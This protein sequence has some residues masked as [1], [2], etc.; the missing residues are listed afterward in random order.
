ME[1]RYEIGCQDRLMHSSCFKLSRYVCTV[2]I[3]GALSFHA[4]VLGM[5][6]GEISEDISTF[7]N[8]SKYIDSRHKMMHN[9][10]ALHFDNNIAS[11]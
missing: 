5:G 6:L 11:P 1:T 2:M 10:I 9:M 4:L 8:S 7:K 3:M